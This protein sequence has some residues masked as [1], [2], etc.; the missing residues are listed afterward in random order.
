MTCQK[1]GGFF[2]APQEKL[3][4]SMYRIQNIHNEL[5]KALTLLTNGIPESEIPNFY[6]QYIPQVTARG[7]Q[8]TEQPLLHT[9]GIIKEGVVRI[10]VLTVFPNKGDATGPTAENLRIHFRNFDGDMEYI[11]R[12][13][14][15]FE[16]KAPDQKNKFIPLAD[17]RWFSTYWNNPRACVLLSKTTATPTILPFEWQNI[18]AMR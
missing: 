7:P 16:S 6:L 1:N 10:P 12:F 5:G 13:T 9:M 2:M 18:E 11:P 3:P 14:L 17:F 15:G 4:V 8:T